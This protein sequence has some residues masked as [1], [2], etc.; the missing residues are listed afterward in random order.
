MKHSKRKRL[1]SM[2][3]NAVITNLCDVDPILGAPESMPEYHTEAK[4]FVPN[5]RIVNLV[6]K[7][8]DPFSI[9]QNNV[10]F[11]QGI[12]IYILFNVFLYIYILI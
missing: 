5:E 2:D 3:V 6:Q 9:S 12:L 7:V 10:P 4:V 8:N 11:I 1:T